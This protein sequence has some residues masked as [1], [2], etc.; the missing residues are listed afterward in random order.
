MNFISNSK[1]PV[2][3]LS[4]VNLSFAPRSKDMTTLKEM[5]ISFI[6]SPFMHLSR[7]RVRS[8]VLNNINI[9]IFEGDRVALMGVNGSSKSTLCRVLSKMYT[10]Q[11]GKVEINKL[12]RAYFDTS[13]CLFPD[14]SGYANANLLA[15]LI[16][17]NHDDIEGLL[18]EV[19]EFSELTESKYLLFQNYSIGMQARLT[20]SLL[21]ALPSEIL[22][23]DE[24]FDGMDVFFQKKIA[25]RLKNIMIQSQALIFVSHS[26]EQIRDVCNRVIILH[27]HEVFFDG[28]LEEGIK[29]YLNLNPQK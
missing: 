20:L 26:I 18:E 23:L 15:S 8:T 7:R 13:V 22:I 28:D 12:I 27:Q 24:V 4:A 16:F 1:V 2:I 21:S 5:F 3:T 25:E 11:S 29:K 14:L 10:P 9:Q 19:F 17:P 6:K